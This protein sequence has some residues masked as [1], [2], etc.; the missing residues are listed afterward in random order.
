MSYTVHLT[1]THTQVSET[2]EEA[3]VHALD[4]IEIMSEG[5]PARDKCC[6]QGW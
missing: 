2:Q 6:S 3:I 5:H 4:C 1:H